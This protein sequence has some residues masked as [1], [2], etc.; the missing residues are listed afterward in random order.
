MDGALESDV[1]IGELAQ[2]GA[3]G[4]EHTDGTR[5]WPAVRPG[6]TLKAR[7]R[8]L[9]TDSG[10]QALALLD[11]AVVSGTSFLTTILIGRSCGAGELGIY[12]LGFSLLVSWGCVQQ[13]L[14][15]IPYTIYR[16]RSQGVTQTEYAGSALVHN[17]LLSVVAFVAM[18]AGALAL[19][20]S[21]TELS[22]VTATLAGVMPFALLREFSRRFAFAHLRMAQALVLDVLVAA[23][24][25]PALAWLAWTGTLSAPSA[26]AIFGAACALSGAVWLYLARSSFVIHWTKVGPTLAQSWSLGRWL[27]ASQ[28][29]I[30]VHAYF[31]HWLLAYL[32][33]PAATGVYAACM[34]VVMFSNPLLL[35]V[36]NA[37]APRAAQAFAEGGAPKLRRV[38]FETT[39]FLG[40]VMALFCGV[41]LFAGADIM[42]L[43]YRG[44]QY[45]GHGHTITLLA[46]AMLAAALGIP[47]SNGLTAAQR[48][49]LT[50]RAGLLA[51]ALSVV[52]VPWLVV[53][54]GVEGAAYGFLAGNIAGSLGRWVGFWALLWRRCGKLEKP[55]SPGPRA[56][57]LKTDGDADS[58]TVIRV[59]QQFMRSSEASAWVIEPLSE[60]VQA[61]IFTVRRRDGRPLF[62]THSRVAVKLYKQGTQQGVDVIR[63]QFASLCQLHAR[64]SDSTIHG[65]RI[66]SP[67]PLYQSERPLALVMTMVPGRPLKALLESTDQVTTETL[68]STAHAVVGAMERL[69]AFDARIHGDFNFDNVLCDL[70][71]K[72]LSFVDPGVVEQAVVCAGVAKRWY[73]A[74][75]DLA[76]LL[77]DMGVSLKRTMGNPA[78][79]RRL[80]WLTEKILRAYLKRIS[81]VAEQHCLLDEIQAC[82][83]EHLKMLQVS[84]S[85]RGLWRRFLRRRASRRINRLLDSLRADAGGAS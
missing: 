47:A 23:V 82:A 84:W 53:K 18:A 67:A 14:I 48:P 39:L 6:P 61:S 40:T 37:L 81:L 25:L 32:V 46:L 76:Y 66:C 2:V 55:V 59:L 60:G 28:A 34:T 38:V 64:L 19:S 15:A 7:A 74:S 43:L 79:R 1:P 30:W 36:S 11:Q 75:R 27:F 26:Y 45:E 10:A 9:S 24:Q 73:P 65:W 35:G 58:P 13:S 49:D 52:L 41:L 78:A 51:V 70:A 57:L 77:F 42:G 62:Q 8:L 20:W 69:W 16:H 22:L 3:P 72:S 33:G 80:E 17:G 83:Q 31:I 54:W 71:S 68:E 63:E 56:Q 21:G 4:G 5:W 44:G 12:S 50:F 85:P 29:T